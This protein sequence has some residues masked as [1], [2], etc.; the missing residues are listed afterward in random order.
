MGTWLEWIGG[1]DIRMED[2]KIK[3]LEYVFSPKSIAVIGAAREPNKIGHVI[4]KNFV[5]G[6]YPGKVYPVNPNAKEILG[7]K[8]YGSVLEIPGNVDCV[9]ISIPTAAVNPVLEQCGK[10]GV[11]AAVVITGGF[12]EIGN[13]EME[14]ELARIA[15]KH[16]IALIGPNCLGTLN[17]ANRVDSIFLPVYKVGRPRAGNIA[18]ISQ[19]GAIGSCIVDLVARAGMG[20][21]KFVSYG[22]ASVIDESHLLEYLADDEKTEIIVMYIEGVKDGRAFLEKGKK[23]A[24]KKP[25]IVLKAGNSDKGAEAAKSHT[26]SLAGSSQAYKAVFRQCK[27]I[28]AASL[29]ELFDF[30]KIFDAP[31]TCGK[32]VAVV[33]NGGGHG[34]LAADAIEEQGLMLA[35]FSSA[36]KARLKEILPAYTN[37]RN[38]V[39]LI[40][41]AGAQRYADAIAPMME[42]E[43]VDMIVVVTLMQTISL[44][45]DVVNV[46]VREADKR[47]KP[48]VVV[49]TGGE[50][51][52]LLR[53]IF[54]SYNVPTFPSP[55]SAVKALSKL[56]YFAE[57]SPECR[58]KQM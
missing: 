40:G 36:T 3:N 10:K 45:A 49:A 18:F 51:T 44:D 22:N 54:D 48:I 50:Y 5:D 9:I 1:R 13:A 39:D 28:E 19:S 26:G 25:V 55:S 7:L 15:E 11:K 2:W 38:P 52:E 30:A 43:N 12:A 8:C 27:M 31:K 17:P 37:L 33:T 21:S 41:D 35:E 4:V 24:G 16:H 34:V 20:M 6:A 56:V 58:K 14:E 46:I 29:E 57:N 32:R 42:D 47:K 23:I 53:R